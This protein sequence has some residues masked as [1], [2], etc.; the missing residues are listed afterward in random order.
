MLARRR[1]GLAGRRG[2]G[3]SSG[4]LSGGLGLGGSGLCA[5]VALARFPRCPVLMSH[6]ALLERG[7]RAP[8]PLVRASWARPL[9]SR[10]SVAGSRPCCKAGGA[11][12]TRALNH[13]S[14]FLR[15]PPPPSISNARWPVGRSCGRNP[16]PGPEPSGR[17]DGLTLTLEDGSLPQA[18]GAVAGAGQGRVWDE[19]RQ[20]VTCVPGVHGGGCEEHHP[21]DTWGQMRRRGRPGWVLGAGRRAPPPHR[22]GCSLEELLPG[23]WRGRGQGPGLPQ[24]AQRLGRLRPHQVLQ[25]DSGR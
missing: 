7:W 18:P 11:V 9:L 22:P 3:P 14:R 17:A 19:P 24:E 6:L 2:R 23:G 1:A 13:Q 16:R 4:G 5:S 12:P 8:V 21:Q 15:P 25:V 10:L 20:Q